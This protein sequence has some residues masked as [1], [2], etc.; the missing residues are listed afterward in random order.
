MPGGPPRYFRCPHCEAPYWLVRVPKS[1]SNSVDYQAVGCVHC[2]QSLSPKDNGF[3]LKYFMIQK[4]YGERR[5]FRSFIC[6]K[7]ASF[8]QTGGASYAK[9]PKYKNTVPIAP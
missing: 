4:P 1:E 7:I 2:N 9:L 5:R 8:I 3:L 6:C